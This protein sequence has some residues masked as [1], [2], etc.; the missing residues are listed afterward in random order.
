MFWRKP[1]L[2][3]YGFVIKNLP[4]KNGNID[5]ENIK[6]VV[7]PLVYFIDEPGVTVDLGVVYFGGDNIEVLRQ[8]LI[9]T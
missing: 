6:V 7:K 8:T 9:Q 5:K 2:T 1:S 4:K 3:I